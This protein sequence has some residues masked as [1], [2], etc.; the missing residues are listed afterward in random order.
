[1]AL[2]DDNGHERLLWLELEFEHPLPEP[3]NWPDPRKM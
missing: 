3:K 1:M 2:K